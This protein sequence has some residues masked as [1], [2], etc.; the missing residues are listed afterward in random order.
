M[1]GAVARPRL[2]IKG[3]HKN[4]QKRIIEKGDVY[5]IA[6][7]TKNRY[8]YFRDQ[9]LCE[10][11]I[12]RLR[13]CQKLKKFKIYAF[14]LL[15]DH[16]HLLIQPY[17]ENNISEIMRSFKTNFSRD[18]NVYLGYTQKA[19]SRDRASN[20]VH[21]FQMNN[22]PDRSYKDRIKRWQERWDASKK[23]IPKFQWQKSFHDHIIRDD[24]DF[25]THFHYT[26]FNFL[27]HELPDDWE[28]SSANWDDEGDKKSKI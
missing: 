21:D 3:M 22:V 15:L 10:F 20:N 12:E 13:F 5:F 19:R 17:G 28:Y 16:F 24:K 14:C 8:P 26:E 23:F 4:S 1:R 18:V 2:Q 6:C 25:E 7:A 9:R 11:W 27:K